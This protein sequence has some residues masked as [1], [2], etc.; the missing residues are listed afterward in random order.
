MNPGVAELH[1]PASRLE[2]RWRGQIHLRR[3]GDHF[4]QMNERRVASAFARF[5]IENGQTAAGSE[6]HASIGRAGAAAPHG[7]RRRA[8]RAAQPV[9]RPVV[10]RRQPGD[11]F[12]GVVAQMLFLDARDAARRAEPQKPLPVVLHMDYSDAE[13]VA[14]I[15]GLLGWQVEFALDT[16]LFPPGDARTACVI[17]S[18]NFGRDMTAVRSALKRGFGYVGLLGPRRRKNLLLGEMLNEGSAL[19]NISAL[20]SPAGLDIG[21]EAP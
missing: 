21:S 4:G 1:A 18:H 11:P 20:H 3:I 2:T 7:I 16:D 9:I 15:A 13:A 6:P 5:G 14:Q 10:D 8:L 17:M 12:F 19:D